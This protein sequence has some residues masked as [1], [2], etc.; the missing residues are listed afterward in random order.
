MSYSLGSLPGWSNRELDEGYIP[1]AEM[2]PRKSRWKV[3]RHGRSGIPGVVF[4]ALAIMAGVFICVTVSAFYRRPQY[5]HRLPSPPGTTIEHVASMST[6]TP[7]E[8]NGTGEDLSLEELRKVVSQSKGY[9]ARD[10]SLNLGWNN[11]SRDHPPDFSTSKD[12][13]DALYN[14][15]RSFPRHASQSHSHPSL[16]RLCSIMRI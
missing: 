13:L 11:V 14:R 3:L 15:N 1:L 10:Y 9:W 12:P 16:L 8:P 6:S 2:R 7:A 4:V 5:V